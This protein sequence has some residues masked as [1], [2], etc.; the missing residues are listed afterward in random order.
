MALQEMDRHRSDDALSTRT[1]PCPEVALIRRRVGGLV[2]LA[3]S[4]AASTIWLCWRAA[5]LGLHPV[6]LAIFLTELVSVWSGLLVG[7]GLASA[8]AQRAVF[9]GDPR[10]SFRFAFAV[11]DAVGRTRSTDLRVDLVASWRAL[12]HRRTQLP[13]LAM[14]AAF[15]DGPRRLVLVV[16]LTLALLL[17]VAPMPLP[18]AWA[19]AC[20]AAA[21]VLMSGS[22]VLL[23]AGRIRFG[24][25]VR[26]SSAALG[27]VCAGTDRDGVAPRRWVG[28]V[29]AVVALNLAGALR[30]MSDRWTHG[31]ASMSA[32]GRLVTMLIAN[33]VVL[34]GLYTLRTTA[35]P[36][37]ENAHLVS[38]HTEERTARQA[39]L[40][41]AVVIGLIGLL[42]GI[43]PDNADTALDA[44]VRVEQV[45]DRHAGRVEDIDTGS[46]RVGAGAAGD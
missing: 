6:E 15:S 1:R 46:G 22:H 36:Q 19:I 29:A 12:W 38:R 37:L 33:V 9:D 8:P 39:A 27:E 18:P 20:G 31:L 45:S 17:G 28:T 32:D 7:I 35:A 42:A 14:A 13:D 25:R 34:G 10:E 23:G 30:G 2:L 26:W 11:A 41:A 24:D 5:Q 4:G 3:A 40:G 43:L 44:P 21:L 16:S